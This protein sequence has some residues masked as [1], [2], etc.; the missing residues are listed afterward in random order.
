[1]GGGGGGVGCKRDI[2]LDEKI[3]SI[4]EEEESSCHP[5]N[6]SVTN[7]DHKIILFSSFVLLLF[8]SGLGNHGINTIL[9]NCTIPTSLSSSHTPK[10]EIKEVCFILSKQTCN[11]ETVSVCYA[12][13]SGI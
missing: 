8:V 6:L 1:M 7:E 4:D 5:G 12:T 2:N 9:T 11:D 3:I 10:V 13:H